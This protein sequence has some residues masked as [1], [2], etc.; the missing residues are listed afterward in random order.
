MVLARFAYEDKR[1][2]ICPTVVSNRM[3]HPKNYF[4]ECDLALKYLSPEYVYVACPIRRAPALL[5]LLHLVRLQHSN[6]PFR[7]LL[8]V[9]LGN[10]IT[11]TEENEFKRLLSSEKN[12]FGDVL[13]VVFVNHTGPYVT[14]ICFSFFYCLVYA[15]Y[16]Y[17]LL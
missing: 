2:G 17:S 9:I 12:V 6:S 14:V 5:A 4:A 1:M 13:E 3:M 11:E 10:A 15:N 8:L 7:K 16:L